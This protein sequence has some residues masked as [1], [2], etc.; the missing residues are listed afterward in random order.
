M[1][2]NMVTVCWK[3]MKDD[4]NLSGP[5]CM[6]HCQCEQCGV[7]KPSK[8]VETPK[9][10]TEDKH[11]EMPEADHD[12]TPKVDVED[13]HV[14][15]TEADHDEHEP[16]SDDSSM[17]FDHDGMQ[18]DQ[19]RDEKHIDRLREMV[20][21]SEAK[22]VHAY[23][24]MTRKRVLEDAGFDPTPTKKQRQDDLQIIELMKARREVR[25]GMDLN[26]PDPVIIAAK[27]AKAYKLHEEMVGVHGFPAF[28]LPHELEF[29]RY[30]E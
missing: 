16:S 4:R 7:V 14:E 8:I 18:M 9:V 23:H 20:H 27:L 1:S 6:R 15:M 24:E 10:D 3:F 5:V 29:F 22:L 11:V 13:E 2:H 19:E 26:P 12:E 17:Y 28:H 25:A 21:H 30:N